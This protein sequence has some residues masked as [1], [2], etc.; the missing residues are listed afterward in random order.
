MEKPDLNSFNLLRRIIILEREICE[1]LLLYDGVAARLR[2]LRSFRSTII[3]LAWS[4]GLGR[5][6]SG[7]A[8]VSLSHGFYSRPATSALCY[9]PVFFKVPSVCFS[10][11]AGILS[12]TL[13]DDSMVLRT[14][15]TWLI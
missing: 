11:T 2:R 5:V 4:V 7:Q 3:N 9:G 6:G 14:G 8:P 1:N 15:A 10:A 13:N 12:K